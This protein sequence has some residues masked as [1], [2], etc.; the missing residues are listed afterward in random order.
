MKRIVPYW[1]SQIIDVDS[2]NV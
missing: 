2:L 1:T